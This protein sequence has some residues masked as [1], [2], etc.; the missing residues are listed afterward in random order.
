MKRY[1]KRSAARMCIAALVDLDIDEWPLRR[2]TR[3]YDFRK[4][5]KEVFPAR[6][7]KDLCHGA[8]RKL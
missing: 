4:K 1:S 3:T 7:N 5:V 2:K 6:A 8:H